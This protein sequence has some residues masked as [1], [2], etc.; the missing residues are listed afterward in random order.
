MFAQSVDNGSAVPQTMDEF[1]NAPIGKAADNCLEFL[2][3]FTREQVLNAFDSDPV[4]F[5]AALG[6]TLKRHSDE[7]KAQRLR[8]DMETM[9]EASLLTMR[10]GHRLNLRT[11]LYEPLRATLGILGALT[12]RYQTNSTF[13]GKGVGSMSFTAEMA[14]SLMQVSARPFPQR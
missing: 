1:L 4:G 5:Q 10:N 3:H 13:H 11:L 6:D 14:S 7:R 2:G 8:D 12:C 9:T